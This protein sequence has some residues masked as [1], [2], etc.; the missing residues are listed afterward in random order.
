VDA[1]MYAQIDHHS[2]EPLWLVIFGLVHHY[3]WERGDALPAPKKLFSLGLLVA[4]SI[5]FAQVI[6]GYL[7]L[8]LL[9]LVLFGRG[10]PQR[11]L[12]IGGM[13]TGCGLLAGLHTLL[14]Y[15]SFAFE[16]I[17]WLH[18]LLL[19]WILAI[20]LCQERW[21]SSRRRLY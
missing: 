3:I 19:L 20:T 7:L 15:P 9:A 13:I 14:G 18:P 4:S 12:F 21:Q 16:T 10:L 2:M 17:S 1:T 8:Y 5:G 6:Y 11:P